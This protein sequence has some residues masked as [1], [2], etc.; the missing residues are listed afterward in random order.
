M[1]ERVSGEQ[2]GLSVMPERGLDRAFETGACQQRTRPK[3][4]AGAVLG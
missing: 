4:R 2:I 1:Q 3:L